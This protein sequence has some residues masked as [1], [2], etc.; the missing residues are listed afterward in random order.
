MPREGYQSPQYLGKF[1]HRHVEDTI[2]T[3]NKGTILHI[4]CDHC[5]ISIP[6]ETL[7][8]GHLRNI[9]Y[10]MGVECNHPCLA[11]SATHEAAVKEFR[12]TDH[13]LERVDMFKYLI[14]IL[15]YEDSD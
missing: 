4:R 6:W 5:N 12:V 15:L 13:V 9:M 3:L 11:V 2:V 14:W 8:E 1:I 10:N 7:L